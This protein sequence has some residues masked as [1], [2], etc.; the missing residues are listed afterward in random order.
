VTEPT[1]PAAVD[2]SRLRRVL[3]EAADRVA[4]V[5]AGTSDWEIGDPTRGQY[6]V[7]VAAD[8]V[9]VPVLLE[10]GLG[11]LSEESGR[12]HTD[13]ALTA[14]ID[15]LD[16]TTNASRG[17]PWFAT[18]ICVVDERGP[19]TALVVDH[20]HGHRFQASRGGGATCDGRPIAPAAPVELG[21]AIVGL[22]DLPPH[23]LGWGQYRTFGALALDLCAVAAGRL[24]AY[25]DCGVDAHGPWDY[26]GGYLVCREAG[27]VIDD[28]HHR[29]L[30]VLDHG[31]RRIPVAAS[32]PAL[33]AEC[34][35]ARA[36][37]A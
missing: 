12:H 11:V 9:A 29:D 19:L 4:D 34:Q 18:S 8:D 13:R 15:P 26:L 33:Q 6:R 23:H 32:S 27:A 10:A 1:A 20:G 24:D 3:D 22:S 30:V 25:I 14:V 37:F 21:E 28:A 16:G 17:L 31:D 7:D 36:S 5:L 35:A 2:R